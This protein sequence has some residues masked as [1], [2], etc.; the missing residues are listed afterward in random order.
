VLLKRTENA[1]KF[2]LR[3]QMITLKFQAAREQMDHEASL[4]KYDDF[5]DFT[6]SC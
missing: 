6:K 1:K 4:K 2:N 3:Q 5:K